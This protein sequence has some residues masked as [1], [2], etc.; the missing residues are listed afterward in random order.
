[1]LGLAVALTSCSDDNKYEAGTKVPGAFFS[2]SVSTS[3]KLDVEGSSFSIPVYRTED[4]PYTINVT[5]TDP[6]GLFTIPATVT[7]P[8]GSTQSSLTIGYDPAQLVMDQ[9]Y[10]VSISLGPDVFIGRSALNFTLV[11]ANPLVTEPFL[12]GSGCYYYGGFLFE[13]DD[14]GLDIFWTYAPAKPGLDIVWTIEH[15]GYDVDLNITCDDLN[16]TDEDGYVTVHV[17]IQFTGLDHPEY[18]E[19]FI[20]D[21]Y[22][23]QLSMGANAAPFE[24]A[25]FFAPAT[26]TFYLYVVYY[27]KDGIWDYGYE[28]FQLDG[29]LEWK[30][31]GDATYADGWILAAFSQN[32]QQMM[33]LDWAYDVP[34]SKYEGTNVAGDLY[35]LRNPYGVASPIYELNEI[36]ADRTIEFR[37]EDENVEIAPQLCGFAFSGF[38]NPNEML[39]GN[40][41]GLYIDY[42][43]MTLAEAAKAAAGQGYA[44]I[45]EDGIVE[46]VL[47]LFGFEGDD[48]GYNWSG[49]LSAYIFLPEAP[50]DKRAE[51]R[52]RA[53]AAP[54]LG[55]VVATAQRA[56]LLGIM[57]S[58]AKK[59]VK[60]SASKKNLN[61]VSKRSNKTIK[62][63]SKKVRR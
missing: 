39:I 25:S 4:A 29:M 6:S 35:R 14:P 62:L 44:T 53:I 61:V 38:D 51:V 63:D 33:P 60:A 34:M 45:F 31:Y 22:N 42:Y 40:I 27:D 7:F 19:E 11:M 32:G 3:I 59:E 18:G 49:Y 48:F 56:K 12:T 8:E 2:Q 50:A 16:A 21:V 47:P 37:I 17:P 52:A 15:W 24:D 20:A 1:M 26:G 30:D 23:Y 28:T 10:E 36:K 57:S 9:P 46:V 13:G 5:S 55:G 58:K 54:K 43:D 41:E